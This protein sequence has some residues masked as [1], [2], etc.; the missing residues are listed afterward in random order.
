MSTLDL[1]AP[2][3]SPLIA[4]IEAIALANPDPDA[5][6]PTWPPALHDAIQA[7]GHSHYT[8]NWLVVHDHLQEVSLEL[9]PGYNDP[10]A[11]RLDIPFSVLDANNVKHAALI[12]QAGQKIHDAQTHLLSL[13]RSILSA[14]DTLQKAHAE[15]LALK[16]DPVR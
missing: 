3:L 11:I 7:R 15:L 8:I 2:A 6:S 16:A 10:T 5:T 4:S 13:Q 9:D 14:Q 12:H 1:L